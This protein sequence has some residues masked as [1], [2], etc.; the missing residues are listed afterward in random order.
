MTISLCHLRVPPTRCSAHNNSDFE[1]F[2]VYNDEG[3]MEIQDQDRKQ[4]GGC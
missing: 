3:E 4:S 2:C 1:T